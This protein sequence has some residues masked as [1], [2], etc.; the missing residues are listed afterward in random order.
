MTRVLQVEHKVIWVLLLVLARVRVEN[1]VVT[2]EWEWED[3]MMSVLQL[4]HVADEEVI[5]VLIMIL[6]RPRVEYMDVEE[7]VIWVQIMMQVRPRVEYMGV[8][9]E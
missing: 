6:V 4:V 5:W 3:S 1:M 8:A 9:G 7:E 2:E